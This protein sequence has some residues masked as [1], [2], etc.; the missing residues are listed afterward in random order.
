[1]VKT[2][3][4][5]KSD[6]KWK[7]WST[8]TFPLLPF[9]LKFGM[10]EYAYSVLFHAKFQHDWY[11]TSQLA[12]KKSTPKPQFLW[13]LGLWYRVPTFPFA[14]DDWIWHAKQPL[15]YS[16]MPNFSSIGLLLCGRGLAI[17]Q[18]NETEKFDWIWPFYF[19]ILP[20]TWIATLAT[21]CFWHFGPWRY[22]L[23][24]LPQSY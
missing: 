22:I 3:N 8:C 17:G 1:M 2:Q 10:W 23:A 5:S 4:N 7:L 11:I 9:G 21:G 6:R 13:N 19:K 15:S 12:A 14:D 16:F 24:W 20:W 18:S